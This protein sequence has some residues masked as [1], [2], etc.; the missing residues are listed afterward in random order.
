LSDVETARATFQQQG[1]GNV[2]E[3]GISCG[4]S[5]NACGTVVAL[6]YRNSGAWML[7]QNGVVTSGRTFQDSYDD[8][9]ACLAGKS[10]GGRDEGLAPIVDPV[11]LSERRANMKK[12]FN[13]NKNEICE[14][15]SDLFVSGEDLFVGLG[16]DTTCDLDAGIIITDKDAMADA[17]AINIVNYRDKTFGKAVIHNGDNRTGAGSGDDERVDIDLDYIPE[18]VKVLWVVV[19]IYTSGFTFQNVKGAYI[20][21]C[22]ARNGHVLCQFKLSDGAVTQRGLVLAKIFRNAVGRW[23]VLAVGRGCDGQTANDRVSQQSSAF[24]M[25]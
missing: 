15:P 8:V 9:L 23:C 10:V 20:R 24:S 19:N 1:K 25:M 14:L 16:W 6:L 22:A 18:Q 3:M 21:L 5:V 4:R 12:T 17:H 13:M 2:C 11:L 7:R